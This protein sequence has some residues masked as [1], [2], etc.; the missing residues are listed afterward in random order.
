MYLLGL[1]TWTLVTAGRTSIPR[2][3]SLAP[4]GSLSFVGFFVERVTLQAFSPMVAL[5]QTSGAQRARTWGISEYLRP[6]KEE[7]KYLDCSHIHV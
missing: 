3:A 7:K 1:G 5:K 2:E 4:L 6:S